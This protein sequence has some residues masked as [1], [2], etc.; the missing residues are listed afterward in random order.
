MSITL[1][2]T[3]AIRKN[4]LLSAGVLFK[5]AA[6]SID[7][8][9]IKAELQRK[10]A[11][12]RDIAEALATAKGGDIAA[13]LGNDLTIGCDQVLSFEDRIFSKPTSREEAADHLRQL[14][15]KTHELLSAV[16]IFENSKLAW[17]HVGVVK[18]TMTHFS[19][20]FLEGYLDRNWPSVS[21]SVGAYKLEEEGVRL[22]SEVDGDYFAVLGMPVLEVLAYL[23]KRG[24]IET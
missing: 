2:S 5:V 10:N 21:E 17:Q 23:G 20:Q 7:E 9:V 19:D 4:L 15:G 8:E 14:R 22:F 18:L 11:T 16:S 12:P 6:S 3:S 24:A 13:R 1:A